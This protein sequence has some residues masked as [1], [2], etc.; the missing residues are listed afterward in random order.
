MM[1]SIIPP[2]PLTDDAFAFV[3]RNAPLVAIDI[4]IRDPGGDILVGLRTNEP[5][6]NT[7]YVPG[8]CIRK[9][10]TV[11]RA[12]D[13]ILTTETGLTASF[14]SAKLLGVYEHFYET[15]R[16]NDP[17]YGTHYVILA[18]EVTLNSRQE[19]TTDS[20]HSE[21]RWMSKEEMRL[22]RDVHRNTKAYVL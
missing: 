6:R 18:Y 7:F 8:G 13:R 3:V 5:A 19:V 12:F 20:Q 10:E 16:F 22:A 9:N 15:N 1:S 14:D 4:I 17:R 11:H 2:T 21:V